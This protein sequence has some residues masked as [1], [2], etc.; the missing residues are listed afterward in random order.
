MWG[1]KKKRKKP[2][3]WVARIDPESLL[4]VQC[5]KAILP[6]DAIKSNLGHS[7]P[8]VIPLTIGVQKHPYLFG[9]GVSKIIWV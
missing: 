2:K 5:L 3:L 1:K 4:V 9:S 7:S 6:K 8:L